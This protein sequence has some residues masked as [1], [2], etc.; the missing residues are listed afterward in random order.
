MQHPLLYSLLVMMALIPACSPANP[1]EEGLSLFPPNSPPVAVEPSGS[2]EF[3]DIID[4]EDTGH[5]R[6][7]P[8]QSLSSFLES[9]ELRYSFSY[10]STVVQTVPLCLDL[11][12]YAAWGV[13][14]RNQLFAD[15]ENQRIS[16]QITLTQTAA[17][18][19]SATGSRVYS[20]S[21]LVAFEQWLDTRPDTDD[22]AT[23]G[24]RGLL[25]TCQTAPNPPD[26]GGSFRVERFRVVLTVSQATPIAWNVSAETLGLRGRNRD[27][28]N[29]DCLPGGQFHNV[30]GTDVYT[31][32]SSI[33]TAAVH[34]GQ[35]NQT[36]GGIV[37]IGILPG[38]PSYYGSTRNGVTS[39]DYNSWPGSYSFE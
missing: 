26:L 31:D 36:Q 32:D 39:M 29:L 12:W 17:R 9:M 2:V 16:V 5:E 13:K 35:I 38:R 8:V 15:P 25:R 3:D 4:V 34:A 7:V 28:F 20:R 18:T 6:A 23:V 30:W 1:A 10:T 11:N 19:W 21:E 37:T 24:A 27:L 33:C 22:R 14:T